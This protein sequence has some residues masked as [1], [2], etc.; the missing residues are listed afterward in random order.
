[1]R[2]LPGPEMGKEGEGPMMTVHGWQGETVTHHPSVARID[3][4]VK[5]TKEALKK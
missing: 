3:A 2:D 1:M 5:K 4:A